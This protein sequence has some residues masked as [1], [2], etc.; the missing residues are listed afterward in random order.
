MA[1]RLRRWLIGVALVALALP[2][3]VG[4]EVQVPKL[5]RVAVTVSAGRLVAPLTI[6]QLSDVHGRF[7]AALE[8]HFEQLAREPKPDLIALTGD[9]LD[10]ETVDLAPALAVVERLKAL[11]A[12]IYYVPGNH[13]HWNPRREALWAALAERGVVMLVNRHEP[14]ELRGQTIT[15][16]G[17]DDAYTGH[18]RLDAALVGANAR[19]FTLLLSH[20]PAPARQLGDKLVDLM[21]AG[22]THGGQVRLPFVGA[23]WVPGEGFFPEYDKGLYP[24]GPGRHL[25]IDSGLGTSLYPVR[26]FNRSQLSRVTVTGE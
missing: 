22:H 8:H 17:V 13:E 6:L 4:F 15:V 14:L 9:L 11:Q 12:P 18:D 1:K 3:W 25:Y 2:L 5:E 7:P 26:L 21:L 19:R 20:S 23:L 24:L 16:A 10:H